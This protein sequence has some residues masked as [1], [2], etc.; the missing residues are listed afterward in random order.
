MNELSAESIETFDAALMEQKQKRILFLDDEPPFLEMLQAAMHSF[1]GDS[2]EIHTA[3]NAGEA[4]AIIQGKHIDLVVVDVEMPVVDGLQFLTLLNR[5]HPNLVKVVLSGGASEAQRA[6]CLSLGAELVLDKAQTKNSWQ[7]VYST[8]NELARVQPDEGFRGVLRRVS[9]Q[10][11][12][13]MECLS[14]SSAV[15]EVSTKE[16][17]GHIFIQD[18]QIIHSEAGDRVGEDAFNYLM[19]L[20]GGEFNLLPFTEP[21]QRSISAT[22]EFLLMESARKRDEGDDTNGSAPES[23]PD[24]PVFPIAMPRPRD[25]Q[26]FP[27]A[28]D[29]PAPAGEP[30]PEIAEMLVCSAQ[31]DLLYEWQ[32]TDANARIGF[33]E[34]LSQ[35][36]RQ[37]GI[38]LPM[39]QFE[40][41]EIHGT[42]TRI[43][44]QIENDHAVFVRTNIVPRTQG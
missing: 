16:I 8:L 21:P 19:T 35:K 36:S 31:G 11:V 29:A 18:G 17:N 6:T 13:Q 41:L 26:F 27:R 10:D 33:L 43:I 38:G 22:W 15:L 20:G 1:A 24:V 42:K 37:V 25:T 34:F 7:S 40:R 44:A 39:G 28:V 14:R 3:S 12:L 23:K 9:L 32:C 30:K 2:W 5:K 4:L